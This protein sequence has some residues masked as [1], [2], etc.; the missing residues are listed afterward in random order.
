MGLR[1]DNPSDRAGRRVA[2]GVRV[3]SSIVPAVAFP[4]KPL[5][6][7]ADGHPR[8]RQITHDMHATARAY[9]GVSEGNV[10]V[11]LPAPN[12]QADTR[13]TWL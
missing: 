6:S 7:R 1:C 5:L 2:T 8:A 10:D 4:V 12:S 3:A 9:V 13:S 11:C